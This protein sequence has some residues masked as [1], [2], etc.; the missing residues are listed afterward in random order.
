MTVDGRHRIAAPRTR[1]WEKFLD[2]EVLQR[3]MPGCDRL[4]PTGD[5]TYKAVLSIGIAAVRGRYEA[6]IQL[7]DLR[8][9]EG[10]QMRVEASGAP[11]FIHAAGDLGFT[12]AYAGATE[13]AY[14]FDVQVGGPIAAVGQRVLGGVSRLLM[15][16]FFSTMERECMTAG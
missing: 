2:P 16:Q 3:A 11:G 9:P 5:G 14:R 6:T 8:E 10:Y 1:V 12:E 7:R 4:E 15:G 13:V